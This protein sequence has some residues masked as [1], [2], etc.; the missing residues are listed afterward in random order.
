MAH[1]FE[2]FESLGDS[3]EFAAA[4]RRRGVECGGLLS[5][6]RS[7]GVDSV[8]RA[9]DKRFDGI[10]RLD[11]L[12]PGAGGAV[13]DGE[14]DLEFTGLPAAAWLEA[15]AI[16]QMQGYNRARE[17]VLRRAAATLQHLAGASRIFIYKS[18]MP[19]P[20]RQQ[21][22]LLASLR[23][24]GPNTLLVVSQGPG[25]LDSPVAEAAPGLL[26]GTMPAFAVGDSGMTGIRV[27]DWEEV[28]RQALRVLGAAKPRAVPAA[29]RTRAD[30]NPAAPAQTGALAAALQAH[31]A[32]DLAAAGAGYRAILAD[33]PGHADALHLLGLVLD[34]Q[35]DGA[36]GA[37]LIRRAIE[38]QPSPR[39]YA[40]LGMVLGRARAFEQAAEACR[41]AL[42]LRPDYPEALSN[43]GMMLSAQDRDAEAAVALRRAVALRP[44]YAEAHLN[45]GH[46]A[47]RLGDLAE[48][49]PAYRTA[50]ALRPDLNPAPAEGAPRK[51]LYVAADSAM[52]GA[53][54]RCARMA[55]AAA[56]AGW[57]ASWRGLGDVSEADARG[58]HVLVLWRAE[59]S[60]MAARLIAYVRAY[61]GQVGIDLDDLIFDP[62]LARSGAIDGIRSSG[63][64]A[65]DVAAQFERV[66]AAL[67]AA[68]FAIA[69]TA[70]LA[71]AIGR[72][73][74]PVWTLP[75]GFD[76]ATRHAAQ[77]A[78]R[79]RQQS[80]GDG[81]V[82]L[83]YAGGTTTHQRDFAE[84]APALAAVLKGRPQARLVLFRDAAG[85]PMVELAE[86]PALAALSGQIEWHVTVKLADLPA[87][88]AGFD[89]NLVPLE[90][91]NPFAAAKGEQKFVEAA[92]AGLPTVASPVGPFARCIVHGETGLHADG[93][94]S[95]TG[96][97]LELIDSPALRGRLASAALLSVL[98]PYGPQ[99]RMRAVQAMLSELG[100]GVEAARAFL[101][102]RTSPPAGVPA[103]PAYAAET[104][105]GSGRDSLAAVIVTIPDGAADVLATLECVR[106]QSLR[107][108]DL[109]VIVRLGTEEPAGVRAWLAAHAGRFNRAAL[110]RL[111]PGG[112]ALGNGAALN[113][114]FAWAGTP[115]V[116]PLPA[117]CRP[118]PGTAVDLLT[119]ASR[120][121]AGYGFLAAPAGGGRRRA[122]YGT[123]HLLAGLAVAAPMLVADWAWAAAGG[124]APG[125]EAEGAEVW[126]F[127]CRLA[128]LAIHGEPA[129]GVAGAAGA[130]PEAARAFVAARHGW[131]GG[132]VPP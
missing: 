54:Y 126:D 109:A 101:A 98:W 84:M 26:T 19:V 120:T 17:Q 76:A 110:L 94:A 127:C 91:D 89:I 63:L 1:V 115:W 41:Q 93:Q 10:F 117:G 77:R 114:G 87:T 119:A 83:C 97:L 106:A 68:D 105:G 108:I 131:L 16:E 66:R 78:A 5:R 46:A 43:L 59:L 25:P 71:G 50:F 52:P 112:A 6:C 130:W 57:Q 75:N 24:H 92:L 33:E 39:Y 100:G 45:L 69:S 86:F 67:D 121:S 42:A 95:W 124:Y 8:I 74:L 99:R 51:I 90:P 32:G 40:N 22:A 28:C 12:A 56:A 20:A 11:R 37:A 104:A 64:A 30:S 21:R 102:G 36:E 13:R 79:V 18:V 2:H 31:R 96:A 103:V 23:R 107:D 4:Q 61:G 58:L 49:V 27:A 82:R 35:G 15:P 9:L 70:E 34:A 81:L 113:A 118:S 116:M 125:P 48:A 29:A 38:Q 7:S 72:T 14:Y 80:G 88:L 60:G 111:K 47:G 85:R 65:E 128:R 44:D 129:G 53:I 122:H 132:A 123:R 3:P 62:D 73:G 55:E